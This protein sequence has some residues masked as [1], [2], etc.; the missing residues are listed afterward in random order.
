MISLNAALYGLRNLSVMDDEETRI[1]DAVSD[2]EPRALRIEV[3]SFIEQGKYE[4]AYKRAIRPILLN[5]TRDEI[6]THI[7]KWAVEFDE[8]ESYDLSCDMLAMYDELIQ[9]IPPVICQNC[10]RVHDGDICP[11]QY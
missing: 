1:S 7:R 9:Y 8:E 4:E 5:Y 3:R 2:V 6:T 11:E 10:G